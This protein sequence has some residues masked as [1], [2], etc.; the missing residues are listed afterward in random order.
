MTITVRGEEIISVE[1]TS[2]LVSL[3]S[4]QMQASVPFYR[5]LILQATRGHLLTYCKDQPNAIQRI[6]VHQIGGR[7]GEIDCLLFKV[8]PKN[9]MN[10]YDLPPLGSIGVSFRL[11]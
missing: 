8:F 4:E 5:D 7:E 1:E 2:V 11:N 10:P 6:E 3:S 9:D